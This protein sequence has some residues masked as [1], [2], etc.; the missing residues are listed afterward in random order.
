MFP[1]PPAGSGSFMVPS[2][3]C[4]ES[5]KSRRKNFQKCIN[6]CSELAIVAVF[7]VIDWAL[8]LFYHIV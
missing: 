5:S 3:G 7:Q 2:I 1:H 6:R 4:N 8:L